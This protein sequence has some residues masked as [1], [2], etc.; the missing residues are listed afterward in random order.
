[1]TR[2]K[3]SPNKVYKAVHT[4]VVSIKLDDELFAWLKEQPNRANYIRTLIERD[5]EERK[6]I[7][8]FKG[9]EDSCCSGISLL[10]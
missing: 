7:V 10:P 4:N 8:D 5:K 6:G 2:P 1:M 3:G 9:K